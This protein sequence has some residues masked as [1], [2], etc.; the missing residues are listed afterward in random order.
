MDAESGQTRGHGLGGRVGRSAA[1]HDDVP[2]RDDALFLEDASDLGPVDA[3]EPGTREGDRTR[4]VAAARLVRQTPAVVA[5]QG[6][7]I[8]E[9]QVWI[10]Q[11]ITEFGG[12][13]RRTGALDLVKT[14]HV[15]VS[16]VWW[17]RR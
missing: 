10:A 12:R 15:R 3:G 14:G 4:D 16:L 7:G 11:A 6:S 8:D 9:D 2:S 17:C 13:D 1:I 5:D